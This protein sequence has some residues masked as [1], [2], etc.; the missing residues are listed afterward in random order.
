M[1]I[2]QHHVDTASMPDGCWVRVL[3]KVYLSKIFTK[4]HPSCNE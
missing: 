3:T 1:Y 2:V 4:I